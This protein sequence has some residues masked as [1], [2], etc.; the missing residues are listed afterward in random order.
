[1]R[2]ALVIYLAATMVGCAGTRFSFE[3]AR[4]VKVGMTETEVVDIMGRPYSVN[5]RGDVQVWIWSFANGISGGHRTVSF[6]F[7][8]GRVATV[9]TI[10]ASFN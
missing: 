3:D 8:D 7:K 5:S 1:M 10:P 9:P 4:R 2:R 6:V